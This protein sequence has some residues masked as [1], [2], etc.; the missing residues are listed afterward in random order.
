MQPMG[1][2]SHTGP[3]PSSSRQVPWQQVE[4]AVQGEPSAVHVGAVQT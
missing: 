1:G 3:T 4:E 2:S